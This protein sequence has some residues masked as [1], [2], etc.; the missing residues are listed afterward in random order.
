VVRHVNGP[1]PLWL[2]D[3]RRANGDAR[4][5]VEALFLRACLTLDTLDDP[6][7][8]FF[9][10]RTAWPKYARE[11]WDAYRVDT[12]ED[13]DRFVATPH[14]L[15]VMDGVLA[16]GRSL[17][18]LAWHI[19]RDHARGFSDLAIADR[20]HLPSAVVSRRYDAA[21]STVVAAAL[22]DRP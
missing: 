22:V 4:R 12:D 18:R 17:D 19:V 3:L 14:D 1:T 16:L 20:V 21:I 7:L 10:V 13:E 2:A 8:R 11:F 9:E 15:S 6:E 5:L